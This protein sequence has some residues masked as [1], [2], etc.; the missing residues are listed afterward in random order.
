MEISWTSSVVV[1][2]YIVI[3][4][5]V[6]VWVSWGWLPWSL[7]WGRSLWWR[8]LGWGWT[9]WWRGSLRWRSLWWW[10]SLV[11]PSLSASVLVLIITNVN[12]SV[13]SI[14][15]S[16]VIDVNVIVDCLVLV[17]I[18]RRMVRLRLILRR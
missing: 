7:G 18:L 10:R 6:L 8:S 11:V 3:D 2:I 1:G 16:I 5:L 4:A 12:M 15:C 17:D 14:S 13:E 9:L